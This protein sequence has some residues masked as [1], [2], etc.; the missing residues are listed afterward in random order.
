MRL[1]KR[2]DGSVLW[3]LESNKWVKSNLIKEAE[4]RGIS[5]ERLVFQPRMVVDEASKAKYLAQFRQADL[6]LDTFIYGAGSTASD[7]LLASLPLLTRTGQGLVSLMAASFLKPLGLAELVTTTDEDYERL[8]L[9]L[10]TN[11]KRLKS[12]KQKLADNLRSS[13]ACDDK[14]FIKHLE[15]GYLQAYQRYFDGKKP[16]AIFVS[17]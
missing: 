17:E 2:V 13:P 5:S 6:Y 3:L 14:L 4:A 10:A 7:A 15:D 16:E 11:P 8:A 12:L 9:E 1:L